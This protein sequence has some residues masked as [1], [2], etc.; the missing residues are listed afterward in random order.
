MVDSVSSRSDR[1]RGDA[2]QVWVMKITR[3]G[4]QGSLSH[5]E[6]GYQ[7]G[8]PDQRTQDPALGERDPRHGADSASSSVVSVPCSGRGKQRGNEEKEVKT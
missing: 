1:A 3:I 2:K 8:K 4:P 5:R 7:T 6:G